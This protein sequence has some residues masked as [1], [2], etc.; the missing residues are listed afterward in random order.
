VTDRVH[1]AVDARIPVGFAGGVQQVVTGL[2]E[3]FSTARPDGLSRTW[4][5]YPDFASWLGPSL[6]PED[7]VIVAMSTTE[8]V[9][10]ALAEK[11][12]SL[13][14][15]A[16][17][18]VQAATD[19]LFRPA[20][21]GKLDRELRARGV[22]VVHLPFQDGLSTALPTVYQPHDLLHLHHAEHFRKA[23]IDHRERVWRAHAHAA[24]A[25]SVGTSWVAEDVASRW[26]VPRDRV[27]VVPLAP[28]GR[29]RPPEAARAPAGAPSRSALR[30]LYPAAFWPHKNHV[31]LI[32]AA[33]A[34]R[35][36]GVPVDLLLPGGPV[37]RHDLVRAEL[38]QHGFDP[39]DVM[40]GYLSDA[41]LVAAYAHAA[42]VCV[43]STFESASFPIWEAFQAGVP[44]AAARVTALPA[45]VG[46]AGLLFDPHDPEDLA[47]VLVRLVTDEP[48]RRTLVAEGRRRLAGLSW[49]RTALA[50]TALYRRV[51][52][53]A[54]VPQ[55][56]AALAQ[57][58]P[59]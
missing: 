43:P 57:E 26:A 41:E 29:L 2:A 30:I 32:R 58:S 44:V 52:G 46:R 9:G 53:A 24:A 5:V 45:Q 3:G 7:D 22:S 49:A 55:E 21:G 37:G 59:L 33:A 35:R 15:R 20:A 1:V 56:E 14:S 36:R 13:V 8:R 25:V 16:R 23:Q 39:A 19:R 17:P 6:P 28:L 34:V 38:V 31:T 47:Q 4:V 10:V 50:T 12:P 48:L 54:P 11:V 51:V 27:H 18:H 40:P 42:A